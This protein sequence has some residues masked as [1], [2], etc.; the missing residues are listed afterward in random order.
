MAR[1]HIVLGHSGKDAAPS[2]IYAGSDASAG[3]AA[4]DRDT[5]SQFFSVIPNPLA[6]RKANPNFKPA[7]A[8]TLEPA[9]AAPP[10]DD[11]PKKSKG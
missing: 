2:V 5:A 10:A 9:P 7:P 1:L 6:R 8:L 4:M 11:K 3:Q